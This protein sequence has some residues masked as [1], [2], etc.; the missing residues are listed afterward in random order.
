MSALIIFNLFFSKKKKKEKAIKD[1]K[2]GIMLSA[3]LYS[4][5]AK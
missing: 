4:D 1:I 3:T 2:V 5:K